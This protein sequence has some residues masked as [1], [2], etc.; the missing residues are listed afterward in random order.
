MEDGNTLHA[1]TRCLTEL[2]PRDESLDAAGPEAPTEYIEAFPSTLNCLVVFESC[3]T[4]AVPCFS[5]PQ[6]HSIPT[7]GLQ[8]PRFL[9]GLRHSQVH[10]RRRSDGSRVS[11]GNATLQNAAPQRALRHRIPTVQLTGV[12]VRST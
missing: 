12:D 9:L 7:R 6:R 3:K 4:V 1:K 2:S 10:L 5:Q 11:I 8:D